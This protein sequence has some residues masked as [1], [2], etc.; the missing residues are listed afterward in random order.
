LPH[1]RPGN[2]PR[3]LTTQ[4]NQ[5]RHHDQRP[6]I[7]A[8]GRVKSTKNKHLEPVFMRPGFH[9]ETPRY[10]SVVSA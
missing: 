5:P 10:P 7:Y 8:K 9:A 6:G 2:I 4:I 3:G 1:Y